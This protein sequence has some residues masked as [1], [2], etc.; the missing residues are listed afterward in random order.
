MIL[1][2][3]K[4]LLEFASIVFKQYALTASK[5]MVALSK[6]IILTRELKTVVLI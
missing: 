3:E 6:Q 5:I 4:V 2:S 1:F